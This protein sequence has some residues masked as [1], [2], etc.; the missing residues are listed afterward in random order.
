M[1]VYEALNQRIVVR[2]HLPGLS[3]E[4]RPPYLAHL[5]RLAGTELPLFEPAAIE[6]MFQATQGLPRKVNLLAQSRPARRPHRQS[7]VRLRRPHPGRAARN[8]LTVTRNSRGAPAATTR[9]PGPSLSALSPHRIHWPGHSGKTAVSHHEMTREPSG[10]I[11]REPTPGPVELTQRFDRDAARFRENPANRFRNFFSAPP[12]I[13]R[14]MQMS[15]K[16]VG[17]KSFSWSWAPL[18]WRR[19]SACTR[20]RVRP[21]LRPPRT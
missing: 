19:R 17:E 4:E 11:T 21:R 8:R 20:R 9:A 15:L 7:Q 1:A 13:S 14:G 12:K 16:P 5:L 3:R 10:G 6:A 2:Y 18:I